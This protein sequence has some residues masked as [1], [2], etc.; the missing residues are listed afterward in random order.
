MA[1]PLPTVSK[2]FAD[3]IAHFKNKVA[4]L[5]GQADVLDVVL[6]DGAGLASKLLEICANEM[7]ESTGDEREEWRLEKDTWDLVGRLYT[8]RSTP[9]DTSPT[10]PTPL[11]LTLRNPYTST[12]LLAE[13]TIAQHSTLRE[14]QLVREWLQETAPAPISASSGQYRA[15]TKH[16]VVHSKR[17]GGGGGFVK[18]LD[19]DAEYRGGGV[20]DTDDASAEKALSRA[21]L[22]HLR[23]GKIEEARQLCRSA[24]HDWR[25]ALIGGTKPFRWNVADGTQETTDDAMDVVQD[26]WAGNKRRKLWSEACQ[27]TAMNTQISP[28]SRALAAS[29]AP[30]RRTLPALLPQCRTFADHAWAHTCALIEERVGAVLERTTSWWEHEDG[31][32][33]IDAELD[34]SARVW[35]TD[36]R[37]ALAGLK[38]VSVD[39][40]AGADH[41]M[42]WTQV[43]CILGEINDVLEIVAERL[44]SGLDSM[45]PGWIRF[46]AHFCLFL[47]MIKQPVP[48]NA[49]AVILEAYIRVLENENQGDL[50]ALYVSALGDNAVDRYA[51]YLASLPDD[52]PRDQRNNALNLARQHNLVVERVAVATADLIAKNAIKELPPLRGPLPT[53]SSMNGDPTTTELR[54]VRSVQWLLFNEETWQTAIFQ[55]NA[56]LRYMLGMGRINA[57]RTLIQSLPESLASS[58]TSQHGGELLGYIKFFGVWDA[59]PAIEAIKAQD[60]GEDGTKN[61]K[62]AWEKE[63][64]TALDDFYE[65][66]LQVL[67]TYWLEL[68]YADPNERR[69]ER[70]EQQRI[71]QIYVPEMVL[72]LHNQLYASRD[73]FPANLRRALQL[74]NIVA[75]SRFGI[76]KDFVSRDGNRMPEYLRCVRE[77]SIAV[78]KNGIT[79]PV[80]AVV[81]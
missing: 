64:K 80:Q 70:V 25:A 35:E 51:V 32:I 65:L 81:G 13:R 38:H 34:E 68:E 78:L 46:F 43:H 18:E 17:A 48:A 45:R 62:R 2:S 56:V 42:H 47:T 74:P 60:P 73:L 55:S 37:A 7:D 20:L 4:G 28:E 6:Q 33:D 49:S 12:S 72:Q 63:Y 41:P 71:R 21:L 58:S 1:V 15:L 52:L 24:G 57:A 27:R 59:I 79:D 54:L 9:D 39:E 19:P 26:D 66:T 69:R 11:E 3:V 40:G 75:D 31:E 5:E 29:L 23:A 77:A 14:L 67:R 36:V 44:Q 50:V 10:L 16:R 30:A 53:V 8:E 76:F 61:E 22:A